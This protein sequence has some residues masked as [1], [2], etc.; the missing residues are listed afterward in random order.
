[1]LSYAFSLISEGIDCIR[2]YSK[3]NVISAY[4][5]VEVVGLILWSSSAIIFR[6]YSLNGFM[7]ATFVKMFVTISSRYL[8]KS[9]S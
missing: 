5:N 9:S 2:L 6:S 8:T 7:R 1:M 4:E 3:Y